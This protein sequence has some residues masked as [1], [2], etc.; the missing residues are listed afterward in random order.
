MG[1]CSGVTMKND[2]SVEVVTKGS[3]TW[4]S[5]KKELTLTKGNFGTINVDDTYTVTA[6]GGTT[7]PPNGKYTCLESGP[8]KKR[9]RQ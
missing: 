8:S 3:G 6:A 2:Q 5:G 7:P 4:E 1:A 9:F